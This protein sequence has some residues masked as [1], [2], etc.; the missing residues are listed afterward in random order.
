MY[1][2]ESIQAEEREE[3]LKMYETIL[4]YKVDSLSTLRSKGLI[5]Y[6][7]KI[8]FLECLNVNTEMYYNIINYFDLFFQG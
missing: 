3:P 7:F 2:Y 1:T 5:L 8:W 6:L 4:L